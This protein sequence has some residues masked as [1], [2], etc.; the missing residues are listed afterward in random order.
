MT[1]EARGWQ[2]KETKAEDRDADG[3]FFFFFFLT[4][5]TFINCFF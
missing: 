1:Q 3:M 2:G 4:L 5:L